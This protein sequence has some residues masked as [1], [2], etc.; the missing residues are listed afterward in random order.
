[1]DDEKN[2]TSSEVEG[3]LEKQGNK[4]VLKVHYQIIA[5]LFLVN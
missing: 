5:Q 4:T 1:M 3:K 2:K